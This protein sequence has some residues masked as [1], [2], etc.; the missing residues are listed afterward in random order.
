MPPNLEALMMRKS[1][2]SMESARTTCSRCERT[3][4]L[5]EYLYRLESDGPLC[6]L[7]LSRLP[8]EDRGGLRSERVRAPD[9][10]VAAAPLGASPQVPR[11]AR[12]P[13][14]A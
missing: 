12:A 3:P 1:V 5:G 4:L 2:G 6:G 11:E 14:A 13:R 9:R 10:T 8:E 7:C